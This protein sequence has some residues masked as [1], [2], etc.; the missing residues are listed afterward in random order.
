MITFT[1]RAISAAFPPLS[2]MPDRKQLSL[3]VDN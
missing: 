2:T 1:E 3:S